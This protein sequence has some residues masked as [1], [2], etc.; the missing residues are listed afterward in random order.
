MITIRQGESYPIFVNL[1]Q[2]GSI[3]TPDLITDM[4]LCIGDSFHKTYQSG[5]LAFDK[6]SQRWYIKLTQDETMAM[7]VGVMVLCCHIKYPDES[8]IIKDIDMVCIT[9][10]CC[11]MEAF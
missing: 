11:C 10:G 2:D 1:T 5:G 3:L 9:G 4:K 6:A 8:V 7:T